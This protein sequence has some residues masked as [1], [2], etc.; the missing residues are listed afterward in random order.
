MAVTKLFGASVKRREDPRLITGQATYTDDLTLPGMLYAHIVR[1][2]HAHAKI[3]RIDTAAARREP[4]V[5]A[6]YTGKDLAGKLN[7]IPTAWLVPNADL[8]TPPHPALATDVVRYVGDGV[9]VVLGETRFAARDAAALIQ[10]E[11]APLPAVVD[12]QQAARDGAV[13]IHADAPKNLAFTWRVAG[14]DAEHAFA[15]AMRGG[16]IVSQRFVNQRLIPNAMETRAVIAKYTSGSGE[17]TVWGTTQN[18]HIARFLMSV[19]TGIPE[20]KVRIIAPEVAEGSAARSRSTRTR[21]SWPT[22]RA[23]RGGP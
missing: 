8:R 21:R 19:V 6:V 2:P 3:V 10:V 11:Y 20:H 7:P 22:A 5:V 9:A 1:S 12:Q 13:Q 4:G 23:P 17:L 18:P 15:D 16:V 14:G